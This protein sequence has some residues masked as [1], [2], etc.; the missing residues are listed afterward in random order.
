MDAFSDQGFHGTPVRDI[1]RRVGVTVPALY[2]HHANKEALLVSLLETGVEDVL[3]RASAAVAEAGDDA[4]RRLRF[5]V[6]AIVVHMTGRTRLAALDSELRYLAPDNRRRY[7]AM[8][9]QVEDL[10]TD[11]L[12]SGLA[13]GVFDVDDPDETSRALLGMCQAIPRWYRPGGPLGARDVAARYVS[14]A[15]RTAGVRTTSEVSS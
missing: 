3:L 4:E 15:C 5:V 1:A 13:A 7:A 6:E 2:Y 14:I 8:R 9:K 12:R 11:I 10:V